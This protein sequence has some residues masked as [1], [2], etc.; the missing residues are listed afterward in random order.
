[1]SKTSNLKQLQVWNV[2]SS[3][4]FL[5]L[6]VCGVL[7]TNE[8]RSANR[9]IILELFEIYTMVAFTS[10]I[11]HATDPKSK[12]RNITRAIDYTPI[13]ASLILFLYYWA[14]LGP[15][16][17]TTL[18]VALVVGALLFLADYAN[19][20]VH[21]FWHVYAAIVVFFVYLACLK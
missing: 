13:V 15:L 8:S 19:P 4:I 16:I 1:M 3:W 9:P 20:W 17:T 11:Y 2:V 18:W 6:G 7:L 14:I 21:P 12:N 10:M 5:I